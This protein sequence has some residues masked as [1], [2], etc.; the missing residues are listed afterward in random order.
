MSEC[1]DDRAAPRQL[2][3]N[4]DDFGQSDAINEGIVQSVERGIVT[5]T[6]AMVRWDAFVSGAGWARGRDLSV[7]LHVD[8]GEEL[9]GDPIGD[10]GLDGGI[11]HQRLD[12]LDVLVGVGDRVPQPHPEGRDGREHAG[13]HDEDHCADATAQMTRLSDLSLEL[14][15][16]L[17]QLG[18]L[19]LQLCLI[20][21]V[22]LATHPTT[23][24]L[25]LGVGATRSEHA[26]WSETS[27]SPSWVD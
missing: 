10:E 1:I 4:A 3:V 23:S 6:S 13:E 27:T 15:V 9:L 7:G 16:A 22:G 2:V 12:C 18:E 21:I 19:A 25:A 14:G 26:L 24:T 5:S 11:R 8:L 17:L 20:G